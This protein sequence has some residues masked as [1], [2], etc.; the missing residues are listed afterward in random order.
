MLLEG[1]ATGSV[2]VYDIIFDIRGS[3][4]D[5]SQ[6]AKYLTEVVPVKEGSSE[7]AIFNALIHERYF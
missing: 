6:Y 2:D 1:L 3:S 7:P 5:V 4:C